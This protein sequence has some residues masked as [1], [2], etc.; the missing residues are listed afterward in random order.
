MKNNVKNKEEVRPPINTVATPCLN[1]ALATV[2][3]TNGIEPTI[4]ETVV[5]KI[6]L[7]LNSPDEMIASFNGTP[8]LLAFNEID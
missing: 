4:N 5:I 2:P 1:S 8:F 6:G 7:N 3:R